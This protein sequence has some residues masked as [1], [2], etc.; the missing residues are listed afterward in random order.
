MTTFKPRKPKT[1]LR[2]KKFVKN[3]VHE[4]GEKNSHLTAVER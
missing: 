4:I 2:R 1:A 3:L